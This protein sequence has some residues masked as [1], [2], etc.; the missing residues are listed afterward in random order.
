MRKIQKL[1]KF[2]YIQN[3]NKKVKK[4][5][6]LHIFPIERDFHYFNKLNIK[7]LIK[8]LNFIYF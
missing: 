8:I 6:Q 5:H 2:V 3:I 1:V 4:N 7:K